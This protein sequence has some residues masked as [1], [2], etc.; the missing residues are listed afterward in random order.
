MGKRV[1][2]LN[3]N[4]SLEDVLSVLRKHKKNCIQDG[5]GKYI[6]PIIEMRQ[7]FFQNSFDPEQ[8][9]LIFNF[10]YVILNENLKKFV[11]SF[12]F[13]LLLFLERN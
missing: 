6:I 4:S 1:A 8:G 9:K 10:L 5:G 7:L 2:A 3:C 13:F 12:R 11:V